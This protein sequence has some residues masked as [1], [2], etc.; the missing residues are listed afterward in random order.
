MMRSHA[1]DEWMEGWLG[2]LFNGAE[3]VKLLEPMRFWGKFSTEF[4]WLRLAPGLLPSM[5]HSHH[6]CHFSFATV[7]EMRTIAGFFCFHRCPNSLHC[8]VVFTFFFKSQH[9]FLRSDLQ[10]LNEDETSK[11]TRNWTKPDAGGLVVQFIEFYRRSSSFVCKFVHDERR[12]D[13]H[14]IHERGRAASS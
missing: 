14:W 5:L 11:L 4:K 8:T 2:E 13:A 12:N 3:L 1:A 9:I 6:S 10:Q 7:S